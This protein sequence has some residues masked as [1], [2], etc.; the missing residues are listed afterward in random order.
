MTPI[1]KARAD[2]RQLLAEEIHDAIN[3]AWKRSPDPRLLTLAVPITLASYAGSLLL[4][5]TRARV[6][7][8]GET[9]KVMDAMISEMQLHAD[10]TLNPPTGAEMTAEQAATLR[11]NLR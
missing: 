2:A 8:D 10:P 11:R 1:E 3:R 6:L 5:L 9:Q 4:Q 7:G